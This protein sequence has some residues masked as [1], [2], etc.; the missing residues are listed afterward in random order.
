[1]S[2]IQN[3]HTCDCLAHCATICTMTILRAAGEPLMIS[4]TANVLGNEAWLDI[5]SRRHHVIAHLRGV[6][7]SDRAGAEVQ[8]V[9]GPWPESVSAPMLYASSYASRDSPADWNTAQRIS[10]SPVADACRTLQGCAGSLV[11]V[12]TSAVPALTSFQNNVGI[13][14]G[15]AADV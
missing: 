7:K 5:D 10:S 4:N 12:G 9:G 2:Y 14:A 15:F 8:E 1:M 13:R 6:C 11:S 3:V